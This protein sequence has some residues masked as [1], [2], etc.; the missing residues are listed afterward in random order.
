MP[1]LNVK[2]NNGERTRAVPQTGNTVLAHGLMGKLENQTKNLNLTFSFSSQG[3]TTTHELLK[4][5]GNKRLPSIEDIK[6]LRWIMGNPRRIFL[7]PC[8]VLRSYS[9]ACCLISLD[10]RKSVLR[11]DI[12]TIAEKLILFLNLKMISCTI[13]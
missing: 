7:S 5:L 9:G 8:P 10:K 6:N 1:H 12:F 3:I 2:V 4:E 13:L 11:D